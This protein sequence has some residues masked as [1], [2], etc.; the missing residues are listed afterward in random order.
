M[1]WGQLRSSNS[2]E[3]LTTRLICKS[4]ATGRFCGG[5]DNYTRFAIPN[6]QNATEEKEIDAELD[7]YES[8]YSTGCSNALI[9]LLCGYYKPLCFDTELPSS[10]P[11]RLPPC[12]E[13]CLYVRKSCEPALMKLLFIGT[14]AI[15]PEKLDCYQFP[16]KG[17]DTNSTNC[18]PNFYKL[19]D[20]QTKLQ[21]PP[22]PG[23][24][25]PSTVQTSNSFWGIPPVNST[26]PSSGIYAVYQC[27]IV[28]WF[29]MVLY[30]EMCVGN[31][32]L[33]HQVDTLYGSQCASLGWWV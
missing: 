11:I 26:R 31:L 20:Y 13:L 8:L 6:F 4:K 19:E 14:R 2:S 21:L 30:A 5:I 32:N 1:S 15:W 16:L 27:C 28:L 18:F 17:H 22:V 12:Q 10:E 24:S 23:V 33:L 7:S 25:F 9:H 29:D 3:D